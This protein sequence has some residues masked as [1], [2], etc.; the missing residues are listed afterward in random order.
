MVHHRI[1][2]SA[3]AILAAVLLLPAAAGAQEAEKDAEPQ[4][5]EQ[6]QQTRELVQEYRQ[7]AQKLQQIRQ[8]AVAANPELEQQS[9]DYQKNVE[10]AIEETG[11]D[12]EAGQEKLRKM[13]KRYKSEDLSE[14]ERQELATDFQTERRKMQQAKQTA[15][16]QEN[17]Q[18]E[19]TKL[20]QDIIAAMK[21]QDSQTEELLQRLRELRQELQAMKSGAPG[22]Q[23]G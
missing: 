4:A 6:Q 16:Q 22:S 21:A 15:M 3:A 1:R 7:T 23:D 18:A 14:E 2:E 8:E 17:I 5:G 9:R 11:Y 19:G 10:Q 13:G 12:F 20:Q